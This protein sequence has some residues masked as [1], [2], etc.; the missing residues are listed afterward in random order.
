MGETFLL[1]IPCDACSHGTLAC[2]N[3]VHFVTR[4]GG[5]MGTLYEFACDCGAELLVQDRRRWFV[6]ILR[7]SIF[8][9]ALLGLACFGVSML[10]DT[11]R[12]G[13]GGN[14]PGAVYL[15]VALAIGV[16][17]VFGVLVPLRLRNLLAGRRR[18]KAI[19]AR[20]GSAGR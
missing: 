5:Q 16:P 7:W 10:L 1:S 14:D 9:P 15:L 18:Y 13:S 19:V 6:W 11:L 2:K 3:T 12:H 8:M 20:Q 17:A 4:A